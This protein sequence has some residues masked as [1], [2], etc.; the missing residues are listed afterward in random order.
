MPDDLADPAGHG[1][2]V[3]RLSE[4]RNNSPIRGF[5]AAVGRPETY[6]IGRHEIRAD[7][8]IHCYLQ[9]EYG[10]KCRPILDSLGS[11][12]SPEDRFGKP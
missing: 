4:A 12:A 3:L 11:V 2:L 6:P 8:R 1:D 5:M 7:S 10:L 9:Q